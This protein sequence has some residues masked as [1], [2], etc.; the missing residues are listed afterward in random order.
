MTDAGTD[1]VINEYIRRNSTEDI[2]LEKERIASRLM[3]ARFDNGKTV[4]VF[5]PSIAGGTSYL[6]IE[7][8]P[9]TELIEKDLEGMPEVIRIVWG[10]EPELRH[11]SVSKDGR[12]VFE[13][14]IMWAE[15]GKRGNN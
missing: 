4:K 14:R 8:P 3:T 10:L 11:I 2:H 9:E 5:S 13:Y 7:F 12:L 15:D 6:C 1:Q